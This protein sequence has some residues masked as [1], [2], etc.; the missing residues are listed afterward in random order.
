MLW[1]LEKEFAA[2]G[3]SRESGGANPRGLLA[4]EG[5]LYNPRWTAAAWPLALMREM[6]AIADDRI[7]SECERF[8]D[9]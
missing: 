1:R 9:L 6:G 4:A 7:T 8:F 3:P 2:T 5:E